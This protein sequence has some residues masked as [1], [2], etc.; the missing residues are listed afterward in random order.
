M[1]IIKALSMKERKIITNTGDLKKDIINA[2]KY[3][4]KSG[5]QAKEAYRDL[6]DEIKEN[7]TVTETVFLYFPGTVKDIYTIFKN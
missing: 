1:S 2:E 6:E 3:Y 7:D 5:R 4:E